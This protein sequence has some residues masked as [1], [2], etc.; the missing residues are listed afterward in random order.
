MFLT[1]PLLKKESKGRWGA[2]M[3][4]REGRRRGRRK[5]GVRHKVRSKPAS[6]NVQHDT[7]KSF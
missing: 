2:K 5:V 7:T 3:G 6:E 4:R 1:S